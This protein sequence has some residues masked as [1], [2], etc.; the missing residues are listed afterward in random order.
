MKDWQFFLAILV[1]IILLLPIYEAYSDADIKKDIDNIKADIQ[2]NNDRLSALTSPLKQ[3]D[4]DTVKENVKQ[5]TELIGTLINTLVEERTDHGNSKEQIAGNADI[6]DY[7]LSRPYPIPAQ[8]AT[9]VYSLNGGR[10]K[11]FCA[12]EGNRMICDRDGIGAWERT[13]IINLGE[14]YYNLRGGRNNKF[15]ADEGDAIRCNRDGA[16]TWETFKILDIG[17]GYYNLIGGRQ[18]KYCSDNAS[19][20]ACNNDNSGTMQRIKISAA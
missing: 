17:D 19:G 10:T 9:G 15:C 7:L 4:I 13:E 14:G 3:K 16:S 2:A 8:I 12:D 11:K 1:F 6:I 18:N 20:I 5:N